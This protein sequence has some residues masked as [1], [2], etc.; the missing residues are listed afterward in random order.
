MK[1]IKDIVKTCEVIEGTGAK[2]GN[3]YLA[4]N[5]ELVTGYKEL[6]FLSRPMAEM[7]K[8]LRNQ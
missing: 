3:S 2:S 8:L 4:V 5:L 1:N 6:I 7:I